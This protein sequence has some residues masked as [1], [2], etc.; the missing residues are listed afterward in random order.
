MAELDGV[1]SVSFKFDDKIV[2]G[3]DQIINKH[4]EQTTTQVYRQSDQVV[5]TIRYGQDSFSLFCVHLMGK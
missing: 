2:K 5:V 1:S 3:R 4:H